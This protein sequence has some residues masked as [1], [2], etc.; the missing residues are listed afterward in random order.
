[1]SS[2]SFLENMLA[3]A[4][5]RL[6]VARI[7]LLWLA[8]SAC[9]LIVSREI[10]PTSAILGSLLAATLIAQFRLWDDLADRDYDATLHPQRVLVTT[11]HVRRFAY[12]CGLLTLPVAATLGIG[13]G[14]EHLAIYGGLLVAMSVLYAAGSTALPRLLRA[15]LV[16]LKYP[17]FIWLSAQD[18]DPLQWARVSAVAYLALCLF[19]LVS[20]SALRRS[21]VWRW[22]LAIE[23]VTLS[24]LLIL[25]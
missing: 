25:M 21:I 13:Y 24:V 1:M 10:S 19:E 22:A 7:V 3:Y 18:A 15:H 14:V 20:D 6:A 4:A 11:S 2:T 5:S 17:V 23:A 9:A 12:L 16:L 8:L